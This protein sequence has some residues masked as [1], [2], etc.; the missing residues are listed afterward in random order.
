MPESAGFALLRMRKFEQ[1]A[2]HP[3]AETVGVLD[4]CHSM[5]CSDKFSR[6]A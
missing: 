2:V 4:T 6:P 1:N 5:N 3:K